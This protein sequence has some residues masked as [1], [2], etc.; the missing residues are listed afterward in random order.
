MAIDFVL[1]LVVMILG[2]NNKLGRKTGNGALR[3]H[4][5][6]SYREVV[7]VVVK[8]YKM[9]SGTSLDASYIPKAQLK[10]S[11]CPH[12]FWKCRFH[13]KGKR[14]AIIQQYVILFHIWVLT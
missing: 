5:L 12:H 3:K 2:V 11:Q 13:Q 14:S 6:G 7:G 9:S 4:S 1:F 8:K 10:V